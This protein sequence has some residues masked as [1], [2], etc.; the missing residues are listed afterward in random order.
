MRVA[1]IQ[2]VSTPRVADNLARAAELLA[3]AR[4]AG[5]ELA[6]LPEYFV[7]MGLRDTDKLAI[8][9]DDGAGPMQDWLA[10]QARL[11]GLWIVG[12]T[13][14]IKAASARIEREAGAADRD[15]LRGA[16]RSNGRS[17]CEDEQR[18]RPPEPA[19]AHAVAIRKEHPFV[20]RMGWPAFRR[21]VVRAR[22]R[23]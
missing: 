22:S 14:P 19:D 3:L 6:V 1:A 11:H 9:E 13:V 23:R 17:H 10:A 20:A 15:G 5:A 4:A 12:G 21:A 7:L 18:S 16:S 8:A 2:T